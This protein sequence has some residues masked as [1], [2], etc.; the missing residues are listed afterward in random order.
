MCIT[1]SEVAHLW[2]VGMTGILCG[3][4]LAPCARNLSDNS[5]DP[6]VTF[7]LLGW[8][9]TEGVECHPAHSENHSLGFR[10]CS[11]AP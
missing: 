10:S 2:Y 4:S 3:W 1:P 9:C 8:R 7:F 5:R 6:H 11:I